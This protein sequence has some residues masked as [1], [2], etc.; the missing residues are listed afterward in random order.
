[1]LELRR[2]DAAEDHAGMEPAEARR[3]R[4][5]IHD[6]RIPRQERRDREGG[7]EGAAGALPP[8][9]PRTRGPPQEDHPPGGPGPGGGRGRGIKGQE[10]EKNVVVPG[11]AES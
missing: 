9:P 7:E 11:L 6:E 2:V 4:L 8:P 3:E 10:L 1:M 5:R